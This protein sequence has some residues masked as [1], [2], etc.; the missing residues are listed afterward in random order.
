[1]TDPDQDAPAGELSAE[2]G[3][4][5]GV[6][7]EERIQ[8]AADRRAGPVGAHRHVEGIATATCPQKFLCGTTDDL[9]AVKFAGN[10]HGDGKGI[11]NEQVVAL[12][13]ALLQAPVP[14]VDLVEVAKAL[15][16]ELCRNRTAHNLNFDP[17]PGV[18]HGSRWAHGHSDRQTIQYVDE[19]RQ[20]FGALNVLHEWV[21]CSGDHQWIYANA[22][23]HHVLSVDHTTFFPGGSAWTAQELEN[24]AE[25]VT[26]DPVL[27][28][29]AL[30]PADHAPALVRLQAVSEADVIAVV[31][32]PPDSWGVTMAERAAVVRFL[33]RRKE[34]V[35][36]HHPS[37]P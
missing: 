22:Q 30:Q 19:N 25:T 20:R 32:R 10:Q 36:A 37:S 11:F 33:T 23:P 7:L 4:I 6:S 21:T 5:P 29:L 34:A 12:L 13:G 1:M 26:P 16:D 8:A 17:E 2:G 3:S 28:P 15:A 35:M 9:Y 24:Q 27:A 14:G 31:A 18:H